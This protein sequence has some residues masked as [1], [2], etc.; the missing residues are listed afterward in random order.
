[1]AMEYHWI[2]SMCGFVCARVEVM[3]PPLS[4]HTSHTQARALTHTHTHTHNHT[5]SLRKVVT[6]PAY[7]GEPCGHGSEHE[8]C[9]YSYCPDQTSG[10]EMY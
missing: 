7:G 5:H 3:T 9:P 6:M 1:M 2:T 4:L 10:M 8:S